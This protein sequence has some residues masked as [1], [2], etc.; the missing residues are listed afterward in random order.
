MSLQLSVILMSLCPGTQ[1]LSCNDHMIT[2]H[3][4]VLGP[5]LQLRQL[6]TLPVPGPAIQR[7]LCDLTSVVW[8]DNGEAVLL[9]FD[10]NP[11]FIKVEGGNPFFRVRL[12]L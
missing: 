3:E 9:I 5:Q 10:A 12:L 7:H 2:L 4:V 1:L 6:V 8:A 11:R